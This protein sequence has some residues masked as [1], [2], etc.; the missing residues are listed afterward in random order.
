MKKLL[1]IAILL[2]IGG[3]TMSFVKKEPSVNYVDLSVERMCAVQPGDS[4]VIY[5]LYGKL[6][7]RPKFKNEDIINTNYLFIVK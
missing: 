4:L 3:I 1:T 7:I 2:L 6:Y 5:Y